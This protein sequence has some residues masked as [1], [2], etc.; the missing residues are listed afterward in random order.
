MDLHDLVVYRRSMK[1]AEGIWTE[2]AD[3][4]PFARYTIG[5]Q[6]IEAADSISANI[7][8]GH[9]RYHFNENHQFCYY[10]RG[11]IQE[12]IT[13]KGHNARSDYG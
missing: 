7:S 5:E 3:W 2:V 11:S 9:G 13:A 10:A 8:E 4:P 12:T 6:L 1:L